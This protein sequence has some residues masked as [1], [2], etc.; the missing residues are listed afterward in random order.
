MREKLMGRTWVRRSMWVGGLAGLGA[1]LL[2]VSLA[3]AQPGAGGGGGG[4]GGPGG[5][6]GGG[7]GR[8]G[9]M[10]GGGQM[11]MAVSGGYVF[12]LAYGTLYQYDA[13]SLELKNK[14]EIPRPQMTGGAAGGGFGGGGAGARGG[15]N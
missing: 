13:T 14:V 12:V 6:P 7:M 4:F 9:G 1:L 11:Q 15:G 2:A 8:M 10:G 5:G 3:V